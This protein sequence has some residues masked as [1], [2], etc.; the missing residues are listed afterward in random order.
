ME[1][2]DPSLSGLLRS[3]VSKGLASIR[4]TLPV[5]RPLAPGQIDPSMVLST[6]EMEILSLLSVGKTE[7]ENAFRLFISVDGVGHQTRV[8]ARKLRVRRHD[9][10]RVPLPAA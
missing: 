7:R 1:G 5:L 6:R 8:I 9:L 4:N 3:R 2:Y 10:P